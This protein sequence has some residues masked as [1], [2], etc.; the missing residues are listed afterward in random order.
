M[1]DDPRQP[2][3]Q[4]AMPPAEVNGDEQAYVETPIVPK[5]SIAG[6]A[7]VAVVA[8]MTFLA[9]LTLG[10]VIL[11]HAQA[12]EWES[13]VAREM[14][15]QVRPMRGRNLDAD[16]A[17]AADIARNVAGIDSV[18]IY[19][20]EESAALLEPWLGSGLRVED[21]PV[22][23][24]IVL[25]IGSAPQPDLQQMRTLLKEQAPSASLDDHR[26][27][28]DRMRTMSQTAVM[29][30]I[31]IL[32]LVFVATVLSVTF[33]T[34]G[35]MAANRPIIEVLHFIGAKDSYIAWNFQQ[36]FLWLGLKGGAIGG[37]AAIVLFVV[38]GL[39]SDRLLGTAGGDQVSALFGS[40]SLGFAGY[41]AVIFLVI[42]VAAVTAWASRRT[43]TQ[44]LRTVS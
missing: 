23:R 4:T 6:H 16:V 39:L 24:I 29:G 8:I 11:V 37:G 41:F 42:L 9:S 35:A 33:A 22:P 14:T 38:A 40:F 10:A 31:A 44:T 7:L 13:D 19:S 34:R 17:R 25:R 12:G 36:H 18:R 43:V 26:G 1:S 32:I 5:S 3:N 30:G 20:K 15:I 21:L 28:I 2:D 27:W